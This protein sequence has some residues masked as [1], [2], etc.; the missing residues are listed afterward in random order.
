MATLD[1]NVEPSFV[2]VPCS[3]DQGQLGLPH[4][5]GQQLLQL[6]VGSVHSAALLESI[7]RINIKLRL[8]C[9]LAR[10]YGF[11]DDSEICLSAFQTRA[12]LFR[13]GRIDLQCSRVRGDSLLVVCCGDCCFAFLLGRDNRVRLQLS[14]VFDVVLQALVAF[15]FL[16][17]VGVRLDG[18]H[19]VTGSHC[20]LAL[21]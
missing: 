5:C 11:G 15:V 1:Q 20:L 4:R 12:H 14:C 3:L 18:L 16:L 7:D 21:V 9:S 10:R 8:H 13:I 6:L 19:E 17:A 2:A